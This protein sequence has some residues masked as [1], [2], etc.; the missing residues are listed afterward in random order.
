MENMLHHSANMP[1]TG[2][3]QEQQE[4]WNVLH[5]VKAREEARE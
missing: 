4:R 5:L 3:G 2:R 1:Y